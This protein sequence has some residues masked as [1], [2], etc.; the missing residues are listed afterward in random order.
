MAALAA[1]QF[2]SLFTNLTVYTYGEPRTG[3]QAFASFINQQFQATDPATTTFFRST[4]N[5]DGIP[6]T[7]PTSLGYVHHG[8]E[9]WNHDPTSAANTDI[10]T[11]DELQCCEA[12]NGT[13][14]NAAHLTYFG[15]TVVIGGQCL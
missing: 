1:A 13:G 3:N 4:H 14:I 15:H 6:S 8:V 10:C 11:G 2:R 7:P 5:N 9:Y 12:L